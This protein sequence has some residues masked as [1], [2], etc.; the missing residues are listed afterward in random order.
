MKVFDFTA[1]QLEKCRTLFPSNIDQDPW[2][3]YHATSSVAEA[4]IESE[5]LVWR[6]GVYSKSDLQTVARI[7][8]GMD[9]CGE[10]TDGYAVLAG[11]SLSV[12]FDKNMTKPVYLSEYS[13]RPLEYASRSFAGG[14]TARAVRIALEDLYSYLGS[15]ELRREHYERQRRRCIRL[16]RRGDLPCRV[17]KVNIEWLGSR[18]QDLKT[19]EEACEQLL[20]RYEYGLVY[21]VKFNQS[22]LSSL[23]FSKIWGLRCFAHLPL[24]RLLAKARLHCGDAELNSQNDE[25][26]RRWNNWRME[27][28]DGLLVALFQYQKEHGESQQQPLSMAPLLRQPEEFRDPSAGQNEGIEIALRHGTAAVIEYIRNNPSPK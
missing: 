14:E 17:I 9:W 8:K 7:Y 26:A 10:N 12:D 3:F 19:L 5:G 23:E 11:F 2:V 16:V 22:D 18:L 28:P 27:H 20:R 6:P 21:A 13:T 1:E 25:D 15:T 24:E 4:A